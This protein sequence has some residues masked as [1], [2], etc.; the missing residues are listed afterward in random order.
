ML[1]LGVLPTAAILVALIAYV[2]ITMSKALRAENESAMQI[3]ADRVAAEIE[4]G[5]TRAVLAAEVMAAAQQNGLFGDR[6]GSLEFARKV[7]A[8]RPEFTGTY[9]GYEPDADGQDAASLVAHPE[10]ASA[11]DEKGR[12]IPYWFRSQEDN[13][14]L[15]LEPLVDMETS[16]YY[17]GC[18]DSFERHGRAMPMVTEPY[19]Y[20]GKMIVEETFPIV[21]DGRFVGIAGVDRALSDISRF[22]HEISDRDQVEIFLLS[23]AGRFVAATTDDEGIGDPAREEAALRTR[24]VTDT[25]YAGLL[26]PL[27]EKRDRHSFLLAEDPVDG[28]RYYYASAP[29][30][31]GGWLVVLRKPESDVVGPI[32][33]RLAT[34]FGLVG[35]A[36]VGVMGLALRVT[37]STSR[38]IG[39]AVEATDRVAAGDLSHGVGID[40]G[41]RDETGLLAA[42]LDRLAESYGAIAGMA[43]S[44]ADGDFSWRMI[45]RSPKDEL[46]VAL[47]EMSEKRWLAEE[48]A[49]RAREEA[50]GAN[51]AKSEFL[52]KMSHE[53]RTPMNAIIGYSEMLEEEA[54]DAGQD[55]FVP[56]LK[57]IQAAGKHLLALINDI[58]DLSKIEAGR[59][60]LYVERFSLRELVDGVVSTI[61]PLVDKQSNTLDVEC[62]PDLG[63]MESDLTKVRQSLFNLLSNA[64]KFTENG[65][66]RLRV[67]RVPGSGGDRIRMAVQDSGIGM[68][69]EQ[70]AR[71]FESFTQAESSTT[72]KYGG[73]GLGLTIT[74]RFCELMGGSVQV[75]SVPGA[76]STFTLDLPARL[77]DGA[78]P[79]A[80]DGAQAGTEAVPP[81]AEEAAAGPLVLVVDDEPSC[82]DLLRRTLTRQGFAVAAAASGE[83]ALRLARKLR[84]R[85]ITLDVMM[86]GSDGWAVL[87]QLKADPELASIPVV[88][89]TILREEKMAYSL[90]ASEYLSKPIDRSRLLAVLDRFTDG[91]GARILIVDDDPDARA[92]LRRQLERTSWTLREAKNGVEALAAVREEPPDLVLLDLMMPEMD[93]FA[94]LEELRSRPEWDGI[95]VVVV[96]A[97]ELSAEE[98]DFL[99]ERSARVFAKGSYRRGDLVSAVTQLAGLAPEDGD[100]RS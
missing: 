25:D 28:E 13:T 15:V 57:K 95:S 60:D 2:A 5:N 68:T 63:E 42:A 71:V 54:T 46:A 19:V 31:T 16:L 75:E 22:L 74:R 62:G 78:A 65:T 98:R 17:Q 89:A 72:R 37:S 53:L 4:R 9:F 39:S 10:L 52:A 90:G 49:R 73:T 27:H 36:L 51:A 88:M 59:M 14:R 12:F 92:L 77:S 32:Q 26:G 33:A 79:T 87:S 30:P 100:A 6:V 20:E 24:A 70:A 84:P 69:P 38:R 21:I 50:E 81:A 56:D 35:V 96:S 93:G 94:F 83:E 8:A 91:A 47:N 41:A 67:E 76:G 66:I 80:G 7:L 34:I 82:R 44:I 48:A 64:C 1:L 58:L 97:R 85:V 43:R 99:Q 29:V 11:M 23:R 55:D 61:S 45:P 18:K 86:P 3:L 40:R